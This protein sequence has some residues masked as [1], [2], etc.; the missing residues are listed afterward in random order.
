MENFDFNENAE[1][2]KATS[3]TPA[4]ETLEAKESLESTENILLNS[5]ESLSDSEKLNSFGELES[6]CAEIEVIPPLSREII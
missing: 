2:F 6:K 4:I 3:E 1:G 5:L